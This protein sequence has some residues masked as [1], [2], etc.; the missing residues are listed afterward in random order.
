MTR[1]VVIFVT[2]QNESVS[3]HTICHLWALSPLLIQDIWVMHQPLRWNLHGGSI[4]KCIRSAKSTVLQVTVAFLC[5]FP[6]VF[7]LS[8]VLL[9][10]NPTHGSLKCALTQHIDIHYGKITNSLLLFPIVFFFSPLWVHWVF[11]SI[12]FWI[13]VLKLKFWISWSASWFERHLEWE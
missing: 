6:L 3:N 5:S 9:F 4:F 2:C 10:L 12:V 1:W 11:L 8:S 13:A 7:Q